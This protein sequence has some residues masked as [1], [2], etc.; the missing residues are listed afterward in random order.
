MRIGI[1]VGWIALA[2]ALVM[3]LARAHVLGWWSP[4]TALI[5][6]C[7]AAYLTY[8]TYQWIADSRFQFELDIDG[9]VMKFRSYDRWQ[10]KTVEQVIS[11]PEVMAAEYYEPQDEASLRL[12]MPKGNVDI[13]L[14]SFGSDA[15]T[16]I[17]HYIRSR[18][19]EVIGI[20][21]PLSRGNFGGSDRL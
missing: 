10:R 4:L 15:E 8:L 5:L 19:V 11:L 14:W 16:K 13:P 7:A 21:N 6:L 2:F 3:N 18:G 12:R 17:V 9:D 1:V 20:P